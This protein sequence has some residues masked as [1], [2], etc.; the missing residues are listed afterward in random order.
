MVSPLLL[1]G[2]ATATMALPLSRLRN[3][4]SELRPSRAAAMYGCRSRPLGSG[5]AN[6]GSVPGSTRAV[7]A[8]R[9]QFDTAPCA[10]CDAVPGEPTAAM[11][12]PLRSVMSMRVPGWTSLSASDV[13]SGDDVTNVPGTCPVKLA[14]RTP[15]SRSSE[16]LMTLMPR[17]VPSRFAGIRASTW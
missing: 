2:S 9:S 1:T 6:A 14:L 4:L 11:R 7:Y 3:Q 10:G 16:V 8:M 5:S 17:W 12:Q 15:A 13:R